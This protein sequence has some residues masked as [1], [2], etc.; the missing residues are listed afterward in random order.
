MASDFQTSCV[1][2]QYSQQVIISE[3]SLS[4]FKFSQ[5]EVWNFKRY[6]YHYYSEP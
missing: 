5:F 3:I 4:V 1:A 6:Y 2:I